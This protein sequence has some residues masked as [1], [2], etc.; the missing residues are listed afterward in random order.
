ME[1][2]KKAEIAVS[3][4]WAVWWA[5]KNNP[6][7]LLF[8]PVFSDLYVAVCCRFGGEFKQ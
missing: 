2:S 1:G 6:S 4:T 7:E 5:G 8:P 3:K